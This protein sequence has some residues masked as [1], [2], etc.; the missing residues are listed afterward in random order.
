MRNR[1]KCKLCGD[2]IESLHVHDFKRC[3]CGEIHIDGGLEY[4]KCGARDWANLLY[5]DDDDNEHAVRLSDQAAAPEDQEE[6]E[7]EGKSEI[8]STH[9]RREELMSML[10]E[11]IKNSENL[12]QHVRS[13]Y[14]TYLDL[15]G[16][17][18][19]I[20]AILKELPS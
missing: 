13:S 18:T 7:P 8:E 2:V 10:L 11:T 1:A 12:P 5:L 14:V 19:L 6:S 9:N 3:K 15:D 4:K 16:A 20:Y 17:L